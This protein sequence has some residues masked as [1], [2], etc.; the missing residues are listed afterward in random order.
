MFEQGAVI[1]EVDPQPL[2]NGKYQLPVFVRQQNF[3]V[4]VLGED[5]GSFCLAAWAQ[6]TALAGKG[7]QNGMLAALTGCTGTA[8]R[9]NAAIEVFVK[10]GF[11]ASIKFPHLTSAC[12]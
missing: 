5:D 6:R 10:A 1:A 12:H 7:D 8:V 9:Q 11:E 4:K 3:F 2:R